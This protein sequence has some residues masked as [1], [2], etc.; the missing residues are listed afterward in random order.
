MEKGRKKQWIVRS[1]WHKR[2]LSYLLWKRHKSSQ[3]M[4][5]DAECTDYSFC[6]KQNT[7]GGEL[8]VQVWCRWMIGVGGFGD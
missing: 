2:I 3:H 7:E 4:E 1:Y 8:H 5:T 6:G